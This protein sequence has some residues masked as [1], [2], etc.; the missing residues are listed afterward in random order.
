MKPHGSVWVVRK[1][2]GVCN[3]PILKCFDNPEGLN[4][5]DFLVGRVPELANGLRLGTA[6]PSHDLSGAWVTIRG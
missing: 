5:G 1:W 3:N 6:V 4:C 2:C